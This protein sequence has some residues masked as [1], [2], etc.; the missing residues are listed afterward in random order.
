VATS[1]SFL[2]PWIVAFK[3]VKAT[4]LTMLGVTLLFAIHRDPIDFVI[5]IAQAIHL[6]LTSR[7]FDRTLNL[8][9][10][11]TPKNEVELGLTALGYAALMGTEGV[12]L[13]LQRSW[14]RWFTIGATSSLIPIEV[15]EIV[16]EP[17]VLRV[18]I[19]VLNVAVVLYLWKRRE[20]F[21]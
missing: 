4:L 12:G 8:A 14:A 17:R 16:R 10:R 21:E 6:P 20:G 1:R 11:A 18:G 5:Q 7:L 2:L 9:F 19:L 15:Y 3:A 13:Y